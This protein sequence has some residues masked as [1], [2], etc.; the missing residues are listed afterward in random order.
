MRRTK[1]S[2]L[3]ELLVVIAIIS[4][5]L[6]ILAQTWPT[7]SIDIRPLPLKIDGLIC[8]KGSVLALPLT[9]GN[10]ELVMSMCVLEHIGL[11]RYGG[12]LDPLG[13]VKALAEREVSDDQM[14]G[15]A[16]TFPI[17]APETKEA[18]LYRAIFA[19]HFPGEAAALTVPA[20]PSIACSTPTALAS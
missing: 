15:A 19:R 20:G 14:A 1:A 12:P 6:A 17:G 9:D 10:T 18:Y 11:G 5:L 8:K 4:L 3:V 2:T 13:T 16:E 7:L